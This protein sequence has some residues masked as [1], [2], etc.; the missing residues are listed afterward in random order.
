M[1]VSEGGR[2]F[3]VPSEDDTAFFN[4]AMELNRDIT[5]AVLRAAKGEYVDGDDPT[6]LDG[7]TASGIR[8]VRAGLAGYA[9][10]LCDRSEAALGYARRNLDRLEIDGE[11]VRDDVRRVLT[12]DRY[13]VVDIDPFGSPMPYADAAARGTDGILCATATD[14]APLCG[15]H[16]P[17]G[18]RRYASVPSI[19]DDHPE[20]GL[21][22]LIGALARTAATHDVAVEPILSHT[23]RHYHRTYLAVEESAT[24]ADAAI[25]RIGFLE[26][27]ES[28]QW[29]DERDGLNPPLRSRCPTCDGPVTR[30]GPLWLGPYRDSQFTRA[31]NE[32]IDDS[33][34]EATKASR[35]LERLAGEADLVGHLDHHVV[36]DRLE[37]PAGPLDA[38]LEGLRDRGYIATRTHFGGTTF[39]TDAPS[40]TVDS[41][42]EETAA[43][44]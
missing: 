36:C 23:T 7:M 3:V 19:T 34:G 32:E 20:I 43:S 30:V 41:V 37:L 31:V 25:E 22:T 2:T 27:C 44:A 16:L 21:R 26:R 35:L 8:G 18:K 13:D 29:G 24:Q 39:K 9:V 40:D 42:V 12:A 33:M 15:A 5:I 14:T 17:A 11:V 28:C 10:T 1:E 6:Y 4:P 38:V